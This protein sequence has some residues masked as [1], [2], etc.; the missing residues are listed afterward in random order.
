MPPAWPPP[1][2]RDAGLTLERARWL[3]RRDQDQE[4]AAAFAAG[5]R[6]IP[7][8]A[9]DTARAA[10]AERQVPGPQAAAPRRPARR[11]WRRR[12]H[13]IG[14]RARPRQD[15]EFLAGFIALRFL[16]DA[17]AAERHFARL[18]EDS[19]SVI[20]RAR[21]AVLAG[22]RGGGAGAGGRARSATGRRPNSPSPSTAS[23]PR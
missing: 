19:R 4:A 16:R 2:P 18:G 7:L 8:P 6:L 22:P 12:R 5:A 11:L 15:A 9:P 20:T 21:S 17:P 14:A 1:R 13:G 10:W 3:R 23:S